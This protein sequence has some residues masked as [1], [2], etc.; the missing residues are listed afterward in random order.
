MF[1]LSPV[2]N[3]WWKFDRFWAAMMVLLPALKQKTPRDST[4]PVAPQQQRHYA[5]VL[6]PNEGT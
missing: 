2:A 5:L 3:W 1:L 4:S 6:T